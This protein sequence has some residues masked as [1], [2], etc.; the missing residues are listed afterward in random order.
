MLQNLFFSFSF[1]FLFCDALNM[2][3]SKILC[4]Y[5]CYYLNLNLEFWVLYR[6][7]SLLQGNISIQS[8]LILA[9]LWSIFQV[10]MCQTENN[11]GR[12]LEI[13]L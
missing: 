13:Q 1:I 12:K 6:I 4:G 7:L 2:Q 9:F 11:F 10:K 3:S 5:F 8:S